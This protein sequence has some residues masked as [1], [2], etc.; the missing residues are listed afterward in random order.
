MGLSR[1]MWP[2]WNLPQNWAYERSLLGWLTVPLSQTIT[3]KNIKSSWP[4][5]YAEKKISKSWVLCLK[6]Q[7]LFLMPLS[8]HHEP[9]TTL[10]NKKNSHD[11]KYVE[12]KWTRLVFSVWRGRP[13]GFM[14]LKLLI[15]IKLRNSRKYLYSGISNLHKRITNVRKD[16]ISAAS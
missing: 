15:S 7:A 10:R 14:D 11:L 5:I 9:H 2:K 12:K 3:K 1:P 6:R 4:E 8:N 13:F 16:I